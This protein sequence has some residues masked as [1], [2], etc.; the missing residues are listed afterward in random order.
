MAFYLTADKVFL[1]AVATVVALDLI[2]RPLLNPR[3]LTG[4]R[5]VTVI[6]L[7]VLSAS[8]MSAGGFS[9]F[10]YFQF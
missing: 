8:A 2:P 4:L 3:W 7:L 6:T 9:P 10:I 1:F 5:G